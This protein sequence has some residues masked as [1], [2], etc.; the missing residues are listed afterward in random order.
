V[1]AVSASHTYSTAGT[2][3]VTAT[4]TDNLGATSTQTAIVKITSAN[5][6]PLAALTVTPSTGY[7]PVTVS[8]STAGSTDPDGTITSSVLNWGDGSSSSGPSG[9]HAYA[10]AGTYTVT[11]I[12]TD[13][14]GATASTTAKVSVQAPQVTISSPVSSGVIA[15][16]SSTVLNSPLHFTASGFSGFPVTSMQIYI[17]ATLVYSINAGAINT[18]LAATPGTHSFMIKAWD[19]SGR[20]F[21]NSFSATVNA[22]PIAALTLN[23]SSIL[24]GGSISASAAASTDSDGSIT[25]TTINFGDGALVSASSATHQYRVAGTYTITATVTDNAGATSSKS[26]SISVKPQYVKI[27]SPTVTTTSNSSVLVSGTSFSGYSIVATQIYLDGSLKAQTNTSSISQTLNLGL[28]THSIT[29]QGWDSSG[30]V[31]KSFMTFTRN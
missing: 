22:P 31:F 19:N 4:V 24:V 26:Q 13:N 21:S 11:A 1:S 25:A 23:A 20:S 10:A 28:G 30:A 16:Q 3:T 17:D 7:A 12:V 15:A 2:F 8:A 27:T 18:S 29:V 9:S 14:L 6:P 5:K